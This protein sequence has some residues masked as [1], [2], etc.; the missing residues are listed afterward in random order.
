MKH[1]MRTDKLARFSSFRKATLKSL[2]VS[3]F[4]NQKIITT[5]AKAKTARR[6]VEKIITIAKKDTLSAKR[7]AFS[8][9]CDH[10][11]VKILFDKIAPKFKDVKGGYTRIIPFK[12]RK[13]DNAELV[14]LELTKTYEVEVKEKKIKDRKETKPVELKKQE[15]DEAKEISK[16]AVEHKI[17]KKKEVK[18]EVKQEEPVE[19][20]PVQREEKLEAKPH[21]HPEE[22]KHKKPEDKKAK[23]LFGGF[24]GF[25]KKERDSL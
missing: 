18:K 3:L 11:L 8:L 17:E 22:E 2:A 7:M 10:G 12:K 24:K 16:S 6:F 14:V 5:K 25:F 20:K 1:K 21:A 15:K 4:E 23:G 9:L 19:H 13:G